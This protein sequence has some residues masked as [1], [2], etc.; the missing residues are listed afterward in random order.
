MTENKKE[1]D[2]LNHPSLKDA[3]A[4]FGKFTK[5][6]LEEEGIEAEVVPEGAAQM[7]LF[8]GKEIRQIFHNNEWHFSI[9]DV[10]ESITGNPT[11]RRYWSDLKRQLSETEGFSELYENIVQLKMP[12]S[13]GK[14]YLT[15]TANTE[16]LFRIV[17]SI[18][19]KAAEP[20]KKWLAKV[21]YERIQEIQDPEI[22]I[23]RAML[24]YKVKGYPDEWINARIQ[25]IVSR[26]ELTNEWSKRGVSE[27]LEYA[28]LTDAIS[29]GTFGLR[30]QDHKKL[31]SLGKNHSLR[32][33][34]TPL[35]L[36]LTML[37]ETTTAEIAKTTDAQGFDENKS[38]AKSGGEVAGSARRDIEKRLG[39]KVV[40]K[41]NYLPASQQKKLK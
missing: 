40:S 39:K 11:P 36:A 41:D 31:K 32:D 19:S 2:P 34:M 20:F 38:A 10:I 4:R 15:D 6:Q 5:D 26:K 35:E 28:L 37:G 18:P 27:G 3:I 33:H 29:V 24:T 30:T 22:A 12:S 14:S 25:T 7:V 17:Q 9:V 23:K 8:K 1:N 21:G 13:D 16:T